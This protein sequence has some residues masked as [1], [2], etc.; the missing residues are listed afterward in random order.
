MGGGVWSM[1]FVGM[2]AY[3]LPVEVEYEVVLTVLSVIPSIAASAAA[4]HIISRKRIK[5]RYQVLGGALIGTGIGAMHF[6]GM[7]AMRAEISMAYDPYL[8]GGAIL[9]VLA[10]ASSAIVIRTQLERRNKWFSVTWANI[11]GAIILGAAISSMHYAAMYAVTVYP[12][13]GCTK[14]GLVIGGDLLTLA[15]NG[16]VLCI[17]ALLLILAVTRRSL[18][19]AALL[20]AIFENNLDGLVVTDRHGTVT[21]FSPAA[22]QMFGYASAEV[23]GRNACFLMPQSM[24]T[25]H[26]RYMADFDPA[27]GNQ[28]MNLTRELNAVRKDGTEFPVEIGVTHLYLQGGEIFSATVRDITARKEANQAMQRAHEEVENTLEKQIELNKLQRQFV[29]MAS[30]EFRTP[31]AIID[32]TAQRL[33]RRIDSLT[34]EDA[35]ARVAQIRK[36][37]SRMAKLMETMLSATRIDEK[38]ITVSVDECDIRHVIVE[39]CEQQMEISPGYKI[40]SDL[41]NMPDTIRGDSALLCQVFTNLLSNAV[42]YSPQSPDIHVKGWCESQNVVVSVM[43]HG[44]GIAEDDLPMLFRRFFRAKSSEGTAG[45]GIGLNLVKR[46]VEAHGGALSVRS[47]EGEGSTFTVR[48]PIAGPEQEEQA[49]MRVA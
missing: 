36:A 10:L 21:M 40:V 46:L 4:L 15:V 5:T 14:N 47:Q 29:S 11:I 16:V 42:K 31:L 1:H 12:C 8:F 19:D 18:N 9:L 27:S 30:H 37:V 25:A 39:A 44:V 45:T 3:S 41:E 32:S 24:R 17:I 28:I 6:T 38:G 49:Q 34:R 2:L 13:D 7:A 20:K 26:I 22:E 43:D 48:V 35:L 23:V 33:A